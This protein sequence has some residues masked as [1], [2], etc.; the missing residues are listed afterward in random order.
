MTR[1]LSVLFSLLALAPLPALAE[2]AEERGRAIAE[3]ADR[4]DIGWQDSSARLRMILRNS[5]GQES[6]RKLRLSSLEISERGF[7]DRS[8]II[9]DSPKDVRG[10]ALLSHTK[11]LEPDDQWLYLPAL[12]RVKRISSKNKSGP[13]VGSEFAFEDLVSSEVDKYSYRWLRNEACGELLCFVL[14]RVPLYENSGYTRQ[15][16]WLDQGEYRSQKIEFY[17]RKGDLLKTLHSE[18]YRQY[19]SQFWRPDLI[20]MENHQ[21]GKSTDL[22]FEDWRLQTGQP[23]SL[24][25]PARLKRQ[26]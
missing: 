25:S 13:F 9:F 18:G 8:L 21:T 19:V 26:R 3:E 12:R 11:I 7:G 1:W 22:F 17:D 2:A 14:E 5:H 4:R 24:F 23:A 20:R 15:I 10:T 6:T 16:Q